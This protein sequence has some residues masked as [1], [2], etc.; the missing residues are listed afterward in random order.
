MNSGQDFVT[1]KLEIKIFPF[2]LHLVR[3][4]GSKCRVTALLEQKG[5]RA[6]L[7]SPTVEAG[8]CWGLI[9][10]ILN[11]CWPNCNL[12]CLALQW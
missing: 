5:L 1:Y 9:S 11:Y 8:Q 10:F 12:T 4:L 2:I 7:R 6:L 3:M